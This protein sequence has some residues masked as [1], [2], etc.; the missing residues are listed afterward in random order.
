MAPY[1]ALQT[2]RFTFSVGVS[3]PVSWVKSGP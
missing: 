3:S 2:L 1:F